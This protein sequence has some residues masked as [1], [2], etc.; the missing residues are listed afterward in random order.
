M[1]LQSFRDKR[2]LLLCGITK[3]PHFAITRSGLKP[4]VAAPLRPAILRSGIERFYQLATQLVA[5][6]KIGVDN[7][8]SYLVDPSAPQ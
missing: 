7:L 8:K 5:A 3:L 1:K 4:A 2:K 6:L